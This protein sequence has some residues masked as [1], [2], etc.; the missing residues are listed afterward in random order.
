MFCKILLFCG[1]LFYQIIIYVLTVRIIF[2]LLFYGRTQQSILLLKCS[3]NEGKTCYDPFVKM[4][5]NVLN[6][7]ICSCI[8]RCLETKHI[9]PLKLFFKSQKI[10]VLRRSTKTSEN[11]PFQTAH[12]PNLR[13]YSL[14]RKGHSIHQRTHKQIN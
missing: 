13:N 1:K 10:H 4:G 9:N 5:K 3:H 6:K 14:S 11:G 12:H 2:S 8:M 7:Q